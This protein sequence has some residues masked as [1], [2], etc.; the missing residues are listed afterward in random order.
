MNEESSVSDVALEI[1]NKLGIECCNGNGCCTVD[2][3]EID[4][5]LRLGIEALEY[6]GYKTIPKLSILDGVYFG[7]IAEIKDMCTYQSDTVEGIVNAFH[8]CVDDYLDFCKEI[9][10][11][12]EKPDFS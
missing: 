9:G 12:P 5:C 11:E 1:C 4:E 7:S 10:K 6:K 8:D 2:G 3:I